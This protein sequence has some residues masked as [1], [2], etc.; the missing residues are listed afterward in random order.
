MKEYVSVINPKMDFKDPEQKKQLFEQYKVFLDAAGK[1]NAAR[2]DT[3]TLYITLNSVIISTVG[4]IGEGKIFPDKN[5][6]LVATLMIIGIGSVLSWISVLS[7]YKTMDYENY[8]IIK[9]LETHFP[10]SIYTRFNQSVAQEYTSNKEKGVL[11][12]KERLIPY[13]FLVG[14][15]L[16]IISDLYKMYMKVHS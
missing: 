6:L 16:F 9:E 1:T 15:T 12:K 5:L 13:S 8:C 2:K 14:Y 11:I 4:A 7:M 3:N 10:S